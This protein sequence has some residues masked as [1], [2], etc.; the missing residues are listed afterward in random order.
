[1]EGQSSEGQIDPSQHRIFIPS[2]RR[3]QDHRWKNT[4][5]DGLGQHSEEHCPAVGFSDEPPAQVMSLVE[6]ACVAVGISNTTTAADS[7]GR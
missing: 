5:S 4:T 2:G 7:S 6:G 1:M 3:K